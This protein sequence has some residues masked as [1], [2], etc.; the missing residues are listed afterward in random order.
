MDLAGLN[1]LLEDIAES[2]HGYTGIPFE[3]FMSDTILK[4]VYA[5][6]DKDFEL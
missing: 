4:T 2:R 3:L 5:D 1:D 6:E